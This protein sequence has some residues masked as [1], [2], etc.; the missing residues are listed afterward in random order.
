[1]PRK[2]LDTIKTRFHELQKLLQ[3]PDAAKNH[4][5]LA[6]Y[7]KEYNEL[8]K[9]H[10]AAER[11]EEIE[12]RLNEAK[13]T[14][15]HETDSVLLEI[16]RDE[17]TSLTE[18]KEKTEK[19]IQEY[20]KPQDPYGKKNIIMEIRA[21]V[22]GDE[23][24]LFAA[25]LFRMYSRFAENKGWKIYLIS[26]SRS[27]IGGMKEI[28]FGINGQN[29]YSHLKYETG[30]HRVQRV[31]ETEKSGRV[32]TSTVTVAVLPE[33]EEIDIKIDP[34]DLRIDTMTAS[35]HGGQS[36]NTTYSAVRVTHLPSGMVVSCQDERSQRQNK[37]KALAVLRSRLLSQEQEK[38]HAER[39]GER[40]TQIGAGMRAEKIRTYNFP[41]DRVTDHRINQSWRNIQGIMD[42]G[43][44]EIVGAL[45]KKSE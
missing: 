38:V 7:G 25:D 22:G 19:E 12:K 4:K 35:G 9:I 16:S 27:P 11:L 32:H 3:D 37:E 42:G 17:I 2:D 29:V 23:A 28:I 21:G 31:P 39:A 5:K 26:A 13:Q 18:Q 40:K 41:Q 36:V 30:V 8:E 14:E 33:A 6:E 45:I 43:L 15:A 24:E 44:N 1:M 10:T 20:L 34:K